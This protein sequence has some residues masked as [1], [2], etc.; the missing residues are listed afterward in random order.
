MKLLGRK[1]MNYKF[2]ILG[3]RV[4]EHYLVLN[5]EKNVFKVAGYDL[6]PPKTSPFL[7]V[8]RALLIS[9]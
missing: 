9:D 8:T 1:I 4:M 2:R 7:P 6:L 5:M 3:L